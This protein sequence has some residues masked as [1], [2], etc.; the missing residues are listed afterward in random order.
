MP[1][2][3]DLLAKL[4]YLQRRARH[5]PMDP[6]A[7]KPRRRRA[8]NSIYALWEFLFSDAPKRV[9]LLPMKCACTDTAL[10][11]RGHQAR[12]FEED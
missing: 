9:W 4:A 2:D 5:L 3:K 12:L 8:N 10:R 6:P 1:L 7:E 11:V